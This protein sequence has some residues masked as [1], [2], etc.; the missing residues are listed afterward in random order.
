VWGTADERVSHSIVQFTPETC[1]CVCSLYYSLIIALIINDLQEIEVYNPGVELHHPDGFSL[2][3]KKSEIDHPASGYGVFIQGGLCLPNPLSLS[4]SL[5]STLSSSLS[6]LL[7]SY[8]H[9]YPYITSPSFS[10]CAFPSFG[11]WLSDIEYLET[12]QKRSR[13][14]SLHSIPA[15]FITLEYDV[16]IQLSETHSTHTHR[17]RK[18]TSYDISLLHIPLS[19]P[20]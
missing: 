15:S 18:D 9:N 8:L 20:I 6:P 13:A 16:H 11:F 14:L 19:L 5:S 3:I 4:L 2:I 1:A 17:E 10:V 12:V 7:L